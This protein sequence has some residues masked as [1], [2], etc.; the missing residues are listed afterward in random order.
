MKVFDKSDWIL[1]GKA[2]AA[3]LVIIGVLGIVSRSCL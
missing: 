1:V 3:C 2:F